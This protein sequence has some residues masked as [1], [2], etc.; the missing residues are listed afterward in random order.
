MQTR[1]PDTMPRPSRSSQAPLR[2]RVLVRPALRPIGERLL[3]RGW[4]AITLRR[5]IVSWRPLEPAELA[6]ELVHVRQWER[7]GTAGF[8]VRYLA[9]SLAAVR[10]GG[11]WYRDNALER[12]AREASAVARRAAPV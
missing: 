11:D 2:V 4:L 3:V 7:L 1:P 6:H 10:H 9:A 8:L 5:T 12:E